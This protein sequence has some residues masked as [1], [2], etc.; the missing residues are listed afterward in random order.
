MGNVFC[1]CL[2]VDDEIPVISAISSDRRHPRKTPYSFQVFIA[3]TFVNTSKYITFF[4]V[5]IFTTNLETFQNTIMSILLYYQRSALTGALQ[6]K[7][8]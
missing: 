4:R 1:C 6:E 2:K 8:L 7:Y 3:L 5:L